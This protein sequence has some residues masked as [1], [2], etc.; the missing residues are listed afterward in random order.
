[1]P[2]HKILEQRIADWHHG[3]FRPAR[4]GGALHREPAMPEATYSFES[5]PDMPGLAFRI[6]LTGPIAQPETRA[7]YGRIAHR[8]A[9]GAMNT[10]LDR[11]TAP[12]HSDMAAFE[13]FFRFIGERGIT[14][15]RTVVLDPDP[16]RHHMTAFAAEVAISVG[17]DAVIR[18]ALQEAQA[19][20]ML[21]DLMSSPPDA[22]TGPP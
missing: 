22:M 12:S 18:H 15:Y 4:E 3:H 19:M 1:M 14:R 20:Q 17:I 9:D 2:P 13:R 11:R 5:I 16:N 6:R 10:I 7:L 21:R 8:I